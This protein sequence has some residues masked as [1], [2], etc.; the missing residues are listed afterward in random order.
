MEHFV[1][2]SRNGNTLEER[3]EGRKRRETLE[4]RR[5]SEVGDHNRRRANKKNAGSGGPPCLRNL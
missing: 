2:S 5:E 3:H 1:V 4:D